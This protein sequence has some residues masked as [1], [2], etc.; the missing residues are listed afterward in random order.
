[1]TKSQA[2]LWA[3]PLLLAGLIVIGLTVALIG[4]SGTWWVLSWTLLTIPV[5][6]VCRFMVQATAAKIRPDDAGP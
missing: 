2:R 6:I 5:A 4:R 3:W 1:M